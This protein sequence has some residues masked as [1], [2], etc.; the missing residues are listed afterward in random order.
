MKEPELLEDYSARLTREKESRPMGLSGGGQKLRVG[1]PLAANKPR[2]TPPPVRP[3]EWVQ[4]TQPETVEYGLGYS[5]YGTDL[6]RRP[7]THGNAQYGAPRTIQVISDAGARLAKGS[8]E[9]PFVVG[10]ISLKGGASFKPD[11]KEHVDGRG[12]DIRPPRLDKKQLPV[13]YRDG[14]YDLE[15]TQRLVDAL[16]ATGG[17]EVIYFNDSRIKGVTPDKDGVR[18]HDNHLHAKM[19]S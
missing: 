11:H 5:V 10:N 14:Q 16:L 8:Q 4:L 9:T 18:I 17:V 19:K 15:G 1:L 12:V 3:E 7:G 6:S 13:T 2:L